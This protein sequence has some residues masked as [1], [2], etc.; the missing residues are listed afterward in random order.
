MRQIYLDPGGDYRI[1][2]KIS[3]YSASHGYIASSDNGPPFVGYTADSGR[4]FT[5][6]F[7]TLGNVNYNGYSVN[8]TFGFD[9]YG[10]KA[11]S[12][13]T[14]IAYGDYG[15]VPA[16]LYSTNGGL[17]YLLVYHSQFSP[18]QL[19]G[20]I[21]DM[22]F[23]ENN[24]IGYAIDADRIL[25][26][27]NK[28]FSWS[29]VRIDPNSFFN[30]IEAVDNNNLVTFSNEYYANKLLKT[31]NAGSSWQVVPLPVSIT[32]SSIIYS[33]FLTANKGW[34]NIRDNNDS[35]RVFYTLNGGNTW[36]QKNHAEATP[37]WCDK[38]KFV[39]DSTGFAIGGIFTTYKTTDSGKVWQPLPRDNNY[40]Y[41][42][43]YYFDI[44]CLN[45]NQLWCGG[46][47]DFLELSTNGGGTP[48]SKAFFKIDTINSYTNNLVKLWNYSKPGYQ[49]KWYVNNNL[50]STSYNATYTHNASSTLDS[51]KLVV[52]N[53][54]NSDSVTKYQYFNLP[55]VITS[56]TPTTGVTGTVVTITGINFTGASQVRFG[57]TLASS[58][59]I[60]SSTQV[61]AVVANGST[62]A[63]TV[64]TPQGTGFLSVFT[65]LP[66]PTIN[67]PT[68]VS[69]NILC[70][71][72]SITIVLQNTQQNVKYELIDSLNN[73]YGSVNSNG[74]T[75]GLYTSPVSRTGN[76]KIKATRINFP[77]STATFTNKIFI[78][79][80]HT[81]SVFTATR[82]N[83]I[84]NEKVN[85]GNQSIDAQTYNWTFHQ[86]A[87]IPGSTQ[88]SPRNIFYQT[89]G[90]KTLTLISTSINGCKDTL[91][92][93]AV[94]VYNKPMPDESCYGLNVDDSD[95]AYFP[96]S[97]A[98]LNAIALSTDNGYYIGGFGNK[99]KLKSRYGNPKHFSDDGLAYFARYT[100][101]G[102]LSW[103][104]YIREGG[105]FYAA[106]KD[107]SGSV[108][109]LGSCQT[110]KYLT[111]TNGDSLKISATLFDTI[112]YSTKVNGF[113]LKLDSNGNYL[114]HTIIDDP[115]SASFSGYP[116]KGGLPNKIK[117]RGNRITIAGTFYA[118][119]A[120]S[121]NGVK[122][123]LV[124]LT[125]STNPNDLQNNFILHIK[126][127]GS[128]LWHMYYENVA[129]NQR[130]AISGIG[131]DANKNIYVAGFYE[132]QVKIHDVGNV[133]NITLN[134]TLGAGS[135]YILKF[136]STGKYVWKAD[137]K[138]SFSSFKSISLYDIATSD[139]G[140][141]YVTGAASVLNSSE[142]FQVISSNGA[143]S[144]ISL[145]SFCLLKFDS[146]GIYKWAQG[147]KYSYY[148][149]GSSIFLKG[150]NL[151]TT[152]SISNNGQAQSQFAFT[153][154]DN[155]LVSQILHE[156]EF[157]V[158]NYDTSGV[159]KRIVKSGTNVGGH[160][161][162]NKIFKDNADNF[163]IGGR[164]DGYNGGN[165]TY[166][167]FNN[168]INTNYIDGFFIKLNPDFCYG[169]TQPTADAGPD[170][171]KCV[172]D[173]AML[174]VSSTGDNY[175]WTSNPAGFT[176][177]LFNPTVSP[178]VTTSY[179]LSAVNS[180]S[181]FIAKDTVTITVLAA[182]L[183]TAGADQAICTGTNAVI[184]VAPVA[185][186]SYSWTS[187]PAGFTSTVANPTITPAATTQYIVTVLNTSGC[188]AKDTVVISVINTIAPS[189]SISIPATS[190]CSGTSV[191]FT[192]TPTNGGTS[193]SYQWQ[194]NG[195]NAG[196][197]SNT[198]SSPSLTNGAQVKVIMTSSL[199]CASPTTANSN[200]ITMTITNSSVP[201]IT[202]SGNTIITAGQ[203]TTISSTITNGG[204][205]PIYQWQDSTNT[206]TWQNIPGASFATIN[207]S[208][209]QSGNK[210]RCILTSNVV[211]ASPAAVTSNALA[212][213]VYPV[214]A[215]APVAASNYGIRCFPNPAY[216]NLFIDSLNLADKWQKLD[217]FSN[218]GKKL[219]TT[220]NI[221]GRRSVTLNVSRLPAGQFIAILRRKSGAPVYLKFIKL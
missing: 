89:P 6:R 28:G 206:H 55:V 186:Y 40:S 165:G 148:G 96:A 62:G 98:S 80:E 121:R 209:A 15:W 9:I 99:P 69:D 25:K 192:A 117:I 8:L 120:Y 152:G 82:A 84:P 16:I 172:G 81:R 129:T 27:T 156:S 59:N 195:A 66:P 175:Y 219:I 164:I 76:Y 71:S 218:D 70:K 205:S 157:F 213:T 174:G 2:K 137:I 151:F 122:Q 135:S 212:F 35:L 39:N 146:S 188:S 17:S 50:I 42:N 217:L 216:D 3:F 119:L 78:L 221:T 166:T 155:M 185:G 191:T 63:V 46:H 198:F 14:I 53:G 210:L 158:V 109:I 130:R 74:G 32:G 93:N 52:T 113:I 215:I 190:V 116:T 176:S 22:V 29:V 179:Y 92:S 5:K 68:S 138:N 97:P 144:N 7:I 73:S 31:T 171:T 159:L 21:T 48:Y 61:N 91:Q 169:N 56:F 170:R 163:I 136:D 41:F 200:V 149:Q 54:I 133:N 131:L 214:T 112:S 147:S 111:L 106:E 115:S 167:V 168:T 160:A 102:V 77:T 124:T 90:Q 100:T 187:I 85:F 19:N 33:T 193:P 173:T 10:V 132:N 126:D 64:T 26:T 114:W 36:V 162:P 125:N 220:L 107:S 20:G 123:V 140:I 13:D 142:F 45:E 178:T 189:V 23:P 199:N 18:T 196:T 104:L 204:S 141:C 201:T 202:V 1:I 30:H 60:V 207:Y 105:D 127:D 49:F 103:Y 75:I 95:F 145:G 12:Q 38:M 153:S 65:Y 180:F 94:M 101:D 24:N 139:N 177:F 161:V 128:L 44:Q 86:D 57:G 43:S 37:F 183:A 58:F 184:G 203:N 34:L 51:I 67:L 208:P 110:Q 87:N 194:V 211:C 79:V 118:N 134:G 47:Q 88:I 108:Y 143:T 4:T 83:I 181:G 154:S 197:N 182:P 150:P 11:F 72:E